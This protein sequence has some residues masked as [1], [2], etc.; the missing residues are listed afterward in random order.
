[1]LL[2][3]NIQIHT[4]A[5]D[6]I[7]NGDILIR[8]KKIV[9]IGKDIKE[10][11][12]TID[13][14]NLVAIP[15][16]VDCHSHVGGVS[17]SRKNSY[18][19]INEMTNNITPD[20]HVIYGIDTESEDFEHA[21]KNGVTT[22]G[23]TPGSGNVVCG[24]A[25][26]AKT[27]GEDI[28]DMTIKSPI[29]LKVA[30]GGNPK[31]TYG[32]R[33]QAPSTRMSI[34]NI[35]KNL[36]KEAEEYM[37]KKDEAQENKEKMPEYD[38]KLEAVIPVLKKE[39]PLKMHCT[40]H[41]MLAAIEIAKEFNLNFTLEHAWGASKYI[42]EIAESGCGVVFGPVGSMRTF[43]ES[44]LIDIESVVE[45]DKRGVLVAL[46]TDAP[47]LSIDS[48][49]HQAGEVVREGGDLEK[50]L[51]MI[52]INPAKI[53]GVDSRIGTIEEGKDGDIVL[54]KGLPAYDTN[55]KIVYTIING[56]VVYSS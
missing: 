56:N 12:K 28:F 32:R 29:A 19:E 46:T 5:G 27:Y 52:T 47:F 55:A 54:F 7:D 23:I 31:G 44:R 36:F 18:S 26:A 39:I 11:A 20:V 4:M 40:Q 53:M 33:N 49:I 24:L 50:V 30:L 45:L 42:E 14:T 37:N 16:L 25:F 13:G 17:F 10:E 43:G 38:S 3:K 48:L 22:L 41:D 9:K 51:K 2:I 21:Y 34:P 8:D 6:I 15:G 1:M 35:M